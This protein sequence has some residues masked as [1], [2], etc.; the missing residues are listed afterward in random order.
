MTLLYIIIALSIVGFGSLLG[1]LTLVINQKILGKILLSLVSLAAGT[2]M[3]GAFLDLLPEG[4]AR[5]PIMTLFEVTLASFVAFLLLEKVLHW[6]HCGEEAD[7]HKHFGILNLIGE[8]IH[9]FI[10]GLIVAAA[11]LTSPAL[12]V[13]ISTAVIFHEIPKEIGDVGVFL[14]AGFGRKKAVLANF[15]ISMIAILGGICGY[16]LGKSSPQLIAY[17]LPIAAGGFIYIAAADLIPEVRTDNSRLNIVS[18]FLLFLL[19]IGIIYLTRG[20]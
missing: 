17:L 4:A 13:T 16:F 10:D 7:A 8:S 6:H 18:S 1:A 12:G 14:H 20:A 3:G 15:V 11:F 5:L 9:N 19:G 2:L